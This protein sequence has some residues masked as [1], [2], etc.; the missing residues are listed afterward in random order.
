MIR[1]KE[2]DGLYYDVPCRAHIT[3]C[4]FSSKILFFRKFS[5]FFAIFYRLKRDTYPFKNVQYTIVNYH[6][7]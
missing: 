6:Y 5:H 2:N 1:H 4:P 7:R 3:F